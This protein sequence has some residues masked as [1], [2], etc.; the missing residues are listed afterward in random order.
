M[1]GMPSETNGYRQKYMASYRLHR[2]AQ[3]L[4]SRAIDYPNEDLT[5]FKERY[6][7]LRDDASQARITGDDF[8]KCVDVLFALPAHVTHEDSIGPN[9]PGCLTRSCPIISA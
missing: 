3:L 2:L 5:A 1:L 4:L 6:L 9:H 8:T 7:G